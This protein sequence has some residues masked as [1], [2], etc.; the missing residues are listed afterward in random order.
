MRIRLTPYVFALALACGLVAPV[1]GLA[2]EP[3]SKV[4][5]ADPPGPGG[6][7]VQ[8]AAG[9]CVLEPAPRVPVSYFM[10]SPNYLTSFAWRIPLSS[11]SAC[12]QPTVLN[13][14][15]VTIQMRW[16][17]ACNAIAEVLIVGATGP[18]GCR[19]P[20]ST[21]VLCSAT[22]PITG[23]GNVSTPHT[24]PLPSGCCITGEAFAWVRLT[25]IGSCMGSGGEMP[26]FGATGASCVNCEQ[27]YTWAPGS[28]ALTEWCSTTNI[29]LLW[30]EVDAD[31]CPA[32]ETHPR[33]WGKVKTIYR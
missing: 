14:N 9:V 26:G 15:A 8:A 5:I 18:S 17:T 13:I 31:C 24:L 32:T 3:P 25:E 11:C 19:V 6:P 4:Q 28:S 33:S 10:Y 27:Y 23:T 20:D 12:P 7:G 16:F 21:N 30:M 29:N 2:D 1:P 22:Y